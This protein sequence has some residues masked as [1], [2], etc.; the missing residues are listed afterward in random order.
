MDQD[1]KSVNR[2][3]VIENNPIDNQ[4]RSSLLSG[5]SRRPNAQISEKEVTNSKNVLSKKVY[6]HD[7]S[8]A[9]IGRVSASRKP[10]QAVDENE[11]E[12]HQDPSR[13]VNDDVEESGDDANET[14]E[15]GID[16]IL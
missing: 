7:A 1:G 11:T 12:H 9:T 3:P 6:G 16:P 8:V 5:R 10:R 14:S 15:M 13:K 2:G 4:T